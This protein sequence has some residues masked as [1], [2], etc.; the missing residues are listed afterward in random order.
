MNNLTKLL[1]TCTSTIVLITGCHSEASTHVEI[2]MEMKSEEEQIHMLET[3]TFDDYKRLLDEALSQATN[4][5]PDA[6]LEKWV[7]RTIVEDKLYYVSDLTDKQIEHLSEQ[8][9]KE[10]QLWK[11]IARED[12]NITVTDKE[13][14]EYIRN[15]PDTSDFPQHLAYAEAL[16]LT[17]EELNHEFDR[18]LYEKNVMWLKLKPKLAKKYG[19]TENNAQVEKYEEE[20]QER[21][22]KG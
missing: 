13:I 1:I 5:N 22:N 21:L 20:V 2:K 15:G 6:H 14:E 18:D 10:D 11:T 12:Y 9:M 17:L 7:I 3:Y 8:A 4:M 19:I 16:G